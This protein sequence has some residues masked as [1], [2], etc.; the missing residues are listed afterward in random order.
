VA[1]VDKVINNLSTVPLVG[2]VG[3]TAVGKTSVAIELARRWNAD[4]VSA[5]SMAIYRHMDIGTAKPSAEEQRSVKFH[6]VDV[7]DPDQPFTVADFQNSAV[8]IIDSLIIADHP[9]LLVGGT[10]LYIKAVIDGLDIPTAGPD[11]D[12]R[13][14]MASLA[15]THGHEY[16]HKLL[17]KA[18]PLTASRLHPNDHKRVVRALEVYRQTGKPLST[19]HSKDRQSRYPG[20]LQFGL[21]VARDDLYNRIERRVDRLFAEGLVAEV[22][23]LLGKGYDTHLPA[24]QGLGYKETAAFIKGECSLDEA[25][26]TLKQGTRRFAKRQLTWF[27]ADKRIHWIDVSSLTPA[28]VADRI[29]E[30]LRSALATQH[31][32][33]QGD[34]G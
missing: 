15:E 7:V 16:V 25:I 4:I 9:V 33:V 31:N 18:D 12:F 27:R 28:E 32:Y 3:P 1:R 24:L 21:D 20:A 14:E 30:E 26:Q 10:G 11:I 2:V 19:M 17:Q 23:A 5:D 29:S 34:H 22:S 6:M 8:E 13:S